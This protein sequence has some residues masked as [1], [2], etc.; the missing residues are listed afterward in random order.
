[1]KKNYALTSALLVAFTAMPCIAGAQ[2][3][4]TIR[5]HGERTVLIDGNEVSRVEK[6]PA[7]AIGTVSSASLRKAWS[8]GT[9]EADILIDEDF[10]A[11]TA[12]TTDEPDGTLVASYY[13]SPGMYID[14]SLT[15][16]GQWGGNYVYSA[17][18]AVALVSPTSYSPSTLFTPLGDYSGD[19]TITFKI[20]ALEDANFYV[21]VCTGGYSAC[22]DA[23]VRDGD[24]FYSMRI[25]ATQGWKEVKFMASNYSADNDGFIEFLNYG[26]VVIDD[27]KVTTTANFLASPKVT[28]ITDY[29]GTSFTA[30]WEPVRKAYNYYLNLYKKVYTS[31]GDVTYSF[32]FEDVDAD[33]TGMPEELTITAAADTL[34]EEGKGSDGTKALVLHDGD[35]ITFPYNLGIYKDITMW[36]HLY[37]PDP[38]GGDYSWLNT[39]IAVDVQEVSGDWTSLATVNTYSFLD[40]K[41]LN[42]T[43]LLK[44]GSF[45]CFRLVISDLPDYDYIA[46]DDISITTGRSAE[47]EEVFGDN[48]LN[49]PEYDMVYYDKTSETS[50]TFTG[51][52]ADSDYYYSVRT[53][54]LYDYSEYKYNRVFGVAAPTATAASDITETSYTANWEVG[55]R[56][57]GFTVN[58]YGV[59][60]VTEAT[61]NYVLL[62]EDF[63]G[64]TEDVTWSADPTEPDEWYMDEVMTLDE[65]TSLPG[66]TA[67]GVAMSVGMFGACEDYSGY[68]LMTPEI[69]FGNNTTFNMYIRAYGTAGDGLVMYV[70]DKVSGAYFSAYDDDG[71]GI[72]NGTYVFDCPY[73]R[74][75]VKFYTLDGGA[76]LIDEVMI[77]QDLSAGALIHTYLSTGDVDSDVYSYT[78]DDID[79]TAYDDYAYSVQAYLSE[80][81]DYAESDFTDYCYVSGEAV[82]K[83]TEADIAS[84]ECQDQTIYEVARY[85]V[86]GKRITGKVK[87]LNIVRMSDG[88]MRKEIVK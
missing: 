61:S 77:M 15:K 32:D 27:V 30:N 62:S 17:G 35:T 44:Y 84:V 5:N 76:F 88:S 21:N 3:T 28:D 73:E 53:H 38:Y 64:I 79:F 18:G 34:V 41:Q 80:D 2:E 33:G 59:T 36:F 20:K 22:A 50:Y 83:A 78:F 16:D 9:T 58:N 57:S 24:S 10:S 85:S 75:Y 37:D 67:L 49:Y 54:Y 52:A 55:S 23:D 42:L 40:G 71:N 13:Y 70:G 39:T 48:S 72:I 47:L 81:G 1:M 26:S 7:T 11:F 29:T 63:S 31:D 45:Y 56:S 8:D 86:D 68:Y 87:G 65:Y 82:K 6:A 25:Y 4:L 51:L 12:G 66:W 14:E 74:D 69:Y 19:L 46:I 43:N 60:C